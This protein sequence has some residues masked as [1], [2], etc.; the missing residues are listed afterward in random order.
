M[1]R[2]IVPTALRNN[3]RQ[4][5]YQAPQVG[6]REDG[7]SKFGKA[8]GAV[9][10]VVRSPAGGLLLSGIGAVK[11]AVSGNRD[12]EILAQL[13]G[14]AAPAGAPGP[15]LDAAPVAVE[16]APD[17]RAAA[18]LERTSALRGIEVARQAA[19]NTSDAEPELMQLRLDELDA[20]AARHARAQAK[21][22]ELEGLDVARQLEGERQAPPTDRVQAIAQARVAAA[23][24]DL[25][26]GPPTPGRRVGDFSSKGNP[27]VNAGALSN[28]LMAQ[29]MQSTKGL[30]L[31]ES[32]ANDIVLR[33]QAPLL[34]GNREDPA[35]IIA[36]SRRE[37]AAD[38]EANRPKTFAERGINLKGASRELLNSLASTV[39][40][41]E[42]RAE[43][44]AALAGRSVF[45]ENYSNI[46]DL[47][48]Q[49]PQMAA[50]REMESLFPER[51][52]QAPA[53]TGKD[54]ISAY[55]V[56]AK[57][58]V[59]DTQ[60]Y[61]NVSSAD[62]SLAAAGT[63]RASRIPTALAAASRLLAPGTRVYGAPV[64]V[65]TV[66][67]EGALTS[68]NRSDYINLRNS[69][70]KAD[71]EYQAL[72]AES[73]AIQEKVSAFEAEA[74]KPLADKSGAVLH[75][76]F[77]GKDAKPVEALLSGLVGGA[78]KAFAEMG[79]KVKAALYKK[80]KREAA[81]G[82]AAAIVAKNDELRM[83]WFALSKM[84]ERGKAGD[85]ER[86]WAY[87]RLAADLR[88][89]SGLPSVA[90]LPAPV[91]NVEQEDRP[92]SDMFPD[93]APRVDKL[94]RGY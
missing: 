61:K 19:F 21:L 63:S 23:Q 2:V 85:A 14:M 81:A 6:P 72:I 36:G 29:E 18:I 37:M 94:P 22:G 66:D 73:D 79:P 56:A 91:S 1:G 78:K 93:G 46:M 5:N 83:A 8:L 58:A 59:G 47:A 49:A 39:E 70:T 52:Y 68:S 75:E 28:S 25:P 9:D 42:Q 30:D 3:R 64:T 90:G 17:P 40:T 26:T 67:K 77:F 84:L 31:A 16:P 35:D 12:E 65:N 24:P 62:S 20:A 80:N 51:S 87:E 53:L 15:A 13:A 33:R 32:N 41:A 89:N 38:A 11:R 57:R 92:M 55:N 7:Y 86:A 76:A 44:M 74:A 54:Y 69:A 10:S 4:Q 60:A 43:V 48:T 45:D 50:R 71:E 27:R 88:L 82:V 34:G